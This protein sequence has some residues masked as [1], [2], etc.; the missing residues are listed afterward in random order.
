MP[1]MAGKHRDGMSGY[2]RTKFPVFYALEM[3]D[4]QTAA[5]FAASSRR[6]A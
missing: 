3:R 2:Y 4:W 6:A 5:A 1:A